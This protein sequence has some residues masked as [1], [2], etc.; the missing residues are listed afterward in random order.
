MFP[1]RYWSGDE[2][3]WY[4]TGALTGLGSFGS[5]VLTVSGWADVGNVSGVSGTDSPFRL[6]S[7]QAR[8]DESGDPNGGG[9]GSFVGK[10]G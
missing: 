3:S 6:P 2:T 4:R 7:E 9:K 5:V 1:M 8:E 10:P